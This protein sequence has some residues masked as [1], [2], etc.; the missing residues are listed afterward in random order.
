M[1]KQHIDQPLPSAIE[2]ITVVLL[3]GNSSYSKEKER[4]RERE[5]EK[6]IKQVLNSND[7]QNRSDFTEQNRATT[8]GSYRD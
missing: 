8:N 4:T 5:K 6:M 3:R 1:N 2:V 7:F